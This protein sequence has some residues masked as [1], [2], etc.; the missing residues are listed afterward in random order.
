MAGYPSLG[1]S[2]GGGSEI[3]PNDFRDAFVRFSHFAQ[4]DSVLQ[5]TVKVKGPP[6]MKLVFLTAFALIVASSAA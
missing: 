1:L 3:D 5:V 4:P 6:M 2:L